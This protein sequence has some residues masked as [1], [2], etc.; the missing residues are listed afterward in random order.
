MNAKAMNRMLEPKQTRWP[1][2]S[3]TAV[4]LTTL[5]L[6]LFGLLLPVRAQDPRLTASNPMDTSVS[7][8]ATVSF[9]VYAT[10]T[11]PPL[12]FQWQHEGTNLP[13]ATNATLVITNVTVAHVGGYKATVWN[14]SND[15]TNSR[16]AILTVD[17]TFSKITTGPV[18]TDVAGWSAPT[19]WDY[20]NDDFLDLYVANAGG[21]DA[22]YHNQRDGTFTRVFTNSIAQRG[23]SIGGA[24]GDYNNDGYEDLVAVHHGGADDLFRNDGEGKFTRMTKAQVGPPVSDAD[25]SMNAGWADYDRDGFIDLFVANA[26]DAPTDDCLYHSNG[27]GSFTKRALCSVFGVKSQLVF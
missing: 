19:W 6:F 24:V 23:P 5:T 7:I 27:D 1:F 18:V 15:S 25:K 13:A 8:G 9:R 16:T 20:D 21:S 4:R 14:A 11:N 22:V 12:T 10:S 2:Q 17:S 3:Q 26:N